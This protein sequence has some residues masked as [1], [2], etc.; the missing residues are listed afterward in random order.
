MCVSVHTCVQGVF[1]P[2]SAFLGGVGWERECSGIALGG[3]NRGKTDKGS[4]SLSVVI[5]ESEC[6]CM[7]CTVC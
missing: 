4:P 1:S 5:G 3:I 2:T 6:G 7:P